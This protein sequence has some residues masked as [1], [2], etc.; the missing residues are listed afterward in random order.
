MAWWCLGT[1][2][3]HVPKPRLQKEAVSIRAL[4]NSPFPSVK[5]E[6]LGL[7]SSNLKNVCLD[8]GCF[9]EFF[10]LLRP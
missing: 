5:N 2:L 9:E 1:R 6:G 3:T 7:G 8:V 10:D 4:Q